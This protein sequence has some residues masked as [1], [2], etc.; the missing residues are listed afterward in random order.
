MIKHLVL[1]SLPFAFLGCGSD[2]ITFA[3]EWSGSFTR[4]KNGCPFTIVGDINPLFPMSIS[5]DDSDTF[6]VV[7]VNGDKAT[8][9]QGR[10]ET[11]SFVARGPKFGIYGSTAPYT[12][13]SIIAEVGYLAVGDDQAQVTVTHYFNDCTNPA[14]PKSQVTCAATYYGDAQRAG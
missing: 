4:L 10:G 9:Q 7:A 5:V 8:G 13:A 1:L 14:S 11:I 2:A 12:C 3:G 6:T